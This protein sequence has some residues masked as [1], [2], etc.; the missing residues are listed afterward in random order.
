VIVDPDG[1]ETTASELASRANRLSRAL[2]AAGLQRGDALGVILSNRHSVFEVALAAHQLGVYYVPINT[3]LSAREAQF[4]VTDSASAALICDEASLELCRAIQFGDN[5][6]RQRRIIYGEG[7][8]CN[9]IE[10][11]IAHEASDRPEQRAAG[12]RLYYTSGTTGVPKGVERPL[13]TGECDE[14]LVAAAVSLSNRTGMCAVEPDHVH[15]VNGPLYHGGPL[16]AAFGAIMLGQRV[17]LMDKW[18]AEGALALIERHTVT[19]TMMVPTMFQRLLSLSSEVRAKYS[20]ESLQRVVH[21]A[22]PCPPDVKRQMIEWMGPIIYEFYSSSEGGGTSISSEEWLRRPGSV[23]RPYE[24][25]EIVILDDQGH[26]CGPTQEGHVFMRSQ[27]PF[28]YRNDAA[29]TLQNRRGDYFTVGDV[30]YLDENGYLYLCDRAADIIISGGVNIYPA[31]VEAALMM[32]PEVHDAGVIGV[33]S[34]E[35]GEEV[36]ALVVADP[37]RVTAEDLSTYLSGRLAKFKHPKSIDIVASLPR[38]IS[39]K[40]SRHR[41]REDNRPVE[42]RI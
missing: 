36:K 20:T 5:L 25:S 10:E 4:I 35:W 11:F 21:A 18:S 2:S 34:L 26:A 32:H 9:S 22:A 31:E 39:G 27:Q 41:L 42:D 33:K 37:K 13:P 16:G 8:G 29:K 12:A 6:P 15:L 17:V 19:T 40:L 38:D 23:G 1:S 7:D 30:G 3:H 14:V 28:Q 24:G